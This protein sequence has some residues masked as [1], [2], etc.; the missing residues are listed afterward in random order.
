M[1][2]GIIGFGR[3]GKLWANELSKFGNVLVYDKNISNQRI[4]RICKSTTNKSNQKINPTSLSQ[5]CKADVLFLLV[6]ISEIKN[7]CKRIKPHLPL[8]TLV[9]DCCSVKAFPA[10]T[11]KEILPK[12]QSIIATHPLFGPD[13]VRRTG[14]LKKH[15]VAFCGIRCS[16][17]QSRSLQKLFKKMGLAVIEC[18]PK[19]HDKQMARS[20][21]LVHF[22]G[23]AIDGLGLKHQKIATPDYETLLNMH[24]HVVHDTWQLFRDMQKFNAFAGPIR[25]QFI[26]GIG[27]LEEKIDAT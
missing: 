27:K 6:P 9:V 17:E 26:K 8:E 19:E 10:K 25:R 5:V 3:F 20:Q 2:F 11:M 1:T 21:C 7:C 4:R 22:I 18:T 14:S 23:R 16:N 24:D 13:S 15:K 12:N